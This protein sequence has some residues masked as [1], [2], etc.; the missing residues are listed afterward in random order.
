VSSVSSCL[1]YD[2]RHHARTFLARMLAEVPGVQ[3]VVAV[4]SVGALM[5]SHAEDRG[6]LLFVGTRRPS[7]GVEAIRR[8]VAAR[9]GTAVV[10]VG[11]R[12]DAP[13]VDA[14][15]AAGA[16]GFLRADA[17]PVLA[18]TLI[19]SLTGLGAPPVPTG[20]SA[21]AL[22]THP[23][24]LASQRE[25]GISRREMQVLYGIS[26]GLSNAG[27]SEELELSENTVKSHVRGLFRGLGVHE[28]AHA[29]ARAYR[30]GLFACPDPG[31]CVD[32]GVLV[33]AGVV[34]AP[35]TSGPPVVGATEGG[36]P[37]TL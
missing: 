13:A 37:A 36:H 27:L 34:G 7:T 3:R 31:V 8:V 29:V 11:E 35:H 26:R 30:F 21:E 1:V 19:Q 2:D 32:G 5:R 6:Q 33:S 4:A 24:R 10:A 23:A 12:E 28:R 17:S 20:A 14:A 22:C 25:L 18:R 9:P 15:L 16:V